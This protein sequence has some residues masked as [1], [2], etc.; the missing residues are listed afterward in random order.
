MTPD[1]PAWSC[2]CPSCV[3]RDAILLLEDGRAGMV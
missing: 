3:A 2:R 1:A